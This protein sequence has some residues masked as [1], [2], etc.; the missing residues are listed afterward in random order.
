MKS[1]RIDQ[2]WKPTSLMLSAVG[3]SLTL[4][5]LPQAS[6]DEVDEADE[7]TKLLSQ[8]HAVYDEIQQSFELQIQNDDGGW[9]TV[10]QPAE[11]AF[12]LRRT[13]NVFRHGRGWIWEHDG[14]PIA[15][16]C[17]W[18]HLRAPESVVRTVAFEFHSLTDGNVR[19]RRNGLVEWQTSV[20]GLEWI[21][22]EFPI[23][24]AERR[25]LR[26]GQMRAIA[27]EYT[28]GNKEG[29]RGSKARPHQVFTKPV[30]RYPGGET[31]T[32]G[33]IFPFGDSDDPEFYMII[34]AVSGKWRI[35]FARSNVL[36]LYVERDGEPIWSCDRAQ[37]QVRTNPFFI[38]FQAE[39]R[40]AS[41]PTTILRVARPRR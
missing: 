39:Q 29:I 23:P 30:Y 15:V 4:V 16:G 32:D 14:R 40:A 7:A 35:A 10:A 2:Q 13:G 28:A 11:P 17:I 3:I 8:W 1:T 24:P 41:D 26:L 27:R 18:S 38:Y 36:R 33:A 6:A 37:S 25:S 31:N 5:L 22:I 12:K 19:A 34:E 21:D 9:T 20:P